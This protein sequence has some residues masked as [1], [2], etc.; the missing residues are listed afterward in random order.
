MSPEL[1]RKRSALKRLC[2]RLKR[3]SQ[4]RSQD[5]HIRVETAPGDVAQVDF[6]YVGML[7]D[8]DS[9][10]LRKAWVF[11]M[12]LGFS[13]KMFARIV[14]DQTVST[15]LR[16]HLQAFQALGGVPRTVVPDYGS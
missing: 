13:R 8:S 5:V 10:V 4:V 11:V 15:W 9:T 2:A 6:G 12:V 16:L 14:F 7:Y 1:A 3:E